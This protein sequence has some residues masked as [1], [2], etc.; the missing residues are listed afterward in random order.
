[1]HN[2]EVIETLLTCLHTQPIAGQLSK[3]AALPTQNWELVVQLALKQQV[4]PILLAYL[5]ERDLTHLLPK[6]V[7]IRLREMHNLIAL[8]NLKIQLELSTI[9][10]E[11]SRQSIAAIVLKGAY[12][13]PKIYPPSAPR[14]VGDIDVLVQPEQLDSAA[15]VLTALGYRSKQPFDMRW[16][17]E[18]HKHLPRF[19][20]EKSVAAVEI[21][22]RL[23]KTSAAAVDPSTLWSRALPVTFGEHRAFA[24]SPEDMLLHICCHAVYDHYLSLDIRF[25]VDIAQIA[26]HFAQDV[27]WEVLVQRAANWDCAR[28]VYIGLLLAHQLLGVSIPDDCLH[29]LSQSVPEEISIEHLKSLLFAPNQWR[30]F[31]DHFVQMQA[32]TAGVGK[33]HSLIRRIFLPRA[34][35][36]VQ[37]HR[38][39]ASWRIYFYYLVRIKDLLRRYLAHSAVH[40]STLETYVELK[41]EFIDWLNKS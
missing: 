9:L 21:H 11:F 10:S 26:E 20:K 41:A 38:E 37:Y 13:A 6:P 19:F 22:W 12:L 40:N 32:E 1:M 14:A 15:Q 39:P 31:S 29:E 27:D 35:L 34:Q 28:G 18:A 17:D 2:F 25:L 8:K 33:I 23:F 3:L 36:A 7:I 30:D 24:L 16:R 4:A 5:D